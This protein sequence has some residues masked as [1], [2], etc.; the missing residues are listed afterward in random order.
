MASSNGEQPPESPKEANAAPVAAKLAMASGRDGCERLKDLLL[1][2]HEVR[3]QTLPESH[4]IIYLPEPD[5]GAPTTDPIED[6]AEGISATDQQASG[7]VYSLS[8]LEGLTLDSDQNSALHVVAASGD[9]Q[10]WEPL[11]ALAAA[12][13]ARDSSGAARVDDQELLARRKNKV[14]ETALHGAVRAGHSKVVEVL[15]KED[16]GLAG[17]DRHD[18]T[19]PLYLAVSLGRFEIAWDLLDMSSRKL[20]YS[21]PDGQN[22]LHVAVQHPQGKEGCVTER[23]GEEEQVAGGLPLLPANN[24]MHPRPKP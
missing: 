2:G 9:S 5:E 13:P 24:G 1:L 16:P 3:C 7:A 4:L 12:A 19:S 21:G 15:M 20:S 22:V 6:Q 11:L 8:L 14:G 18:G 23:E 10:A 17:V